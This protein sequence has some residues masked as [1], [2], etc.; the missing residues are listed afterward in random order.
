MRDKYH[1]LV[2][3]LAI[4]IVLFSPI[5]ETALFMWFRSFFLMNETVLEQYFQQYLNLY[6]GEDK[7]ISK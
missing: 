7:L 2:A 6:K 5:L 4:F 1:I 3:T